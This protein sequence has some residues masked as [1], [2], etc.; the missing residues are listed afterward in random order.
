MK[1]RAWLFFACLTFS[2]AWAQTPSVYAIT[3]AKVYPVNGPAIE[4]GTVV[5]RN[6][7]IEAVGANI[8]V[9]SDAWIID[10]TGLNVY[11]GLIDALSNTGLPTE[12]QAPSRTAFPARGTAPALTPTL[13]AAPPRRVAGPEDRP[14]TTSW[15]HAAD[16]MNPADPKFT[17]MRQAGFTT[18][19]IFPMRG[20]IAGQGALVNLANGKAGDAVVSPSTGQLYTTQ[21]GSFGIFPGSL[22]GVF[23]YIR[24][25]HIDARYYQEQ[26]QRYEKNPN[27]QTRPSYDKALEGVL[28]SSRTFLPAVQRREIE[29][30][31]TF[32]SELLG[33]PVIYG[34]HEGYETAALLAAK[35]IPVIVNLQWPEVARDADPAAYQELAQLRLRKYAPSTPAAF[36]KNGVLFGFST[37]GIERGSDVWKAVRKAKTSGLSQEAAISAF[38]LNAAKIYGVSDRLGSIEPGKIANLLITKGELFDESTKVQFLMIDG[39]KVD[40][41]AETPEVPAGFPGRGLRPSTEEGVQ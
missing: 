4:Q 29:R 14:S 41:P 2:L 23:S 18:A 27:G 12:Y 25:I 19:A 17:A 8:N 36:V 32:S 28:E 39:K 31:V 10:G 37:Q 13:P 6:G 34:A 33:T 16:V 5:V 24:Q 11:P 9:P 20:V 38:T 1:R 26:K 40:V 3:K 35:K 21:I 22:L 15:V 30:M 7:L